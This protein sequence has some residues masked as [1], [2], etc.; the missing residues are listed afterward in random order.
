MKVKTDRDWYEAQYKNRDSEYSRCYANGIP[1]TAQEENGFCVDYAIALLNLLPGRDRILD[2]GSGYGY[3]MDAWER[4]GFQVTGLE[5]SETAV[6]GSGK[7]NMLCGDIRDLSRFKDGEFAIAYSQATLE[8]LE[9]DDIKKVVQDIHRIAQCG[10]HYVGHD[11]GTDPSHITCVPP[12]EFFKWLTDWMVEI[13]GGVASFGNP[14][15]SIYPIFIT[16]VE[17]PLRIRCSMYL[18]DLYAAKEK[19]REENNRDD[20]ADIAPILRTGT[21]GD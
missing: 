15:Q 3:T 12:G 4:R 2:L 18:S 7:R 11:A 17:W 8:H 6:K 9:R 19:A 1:R 14:M 5:W 16:A 13:D 21:G 10:V 20:P